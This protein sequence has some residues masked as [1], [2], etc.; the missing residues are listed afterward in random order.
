MTGPLFKWFGSKW[1]SAKH[2]PKPIFDSIVEPFAGG[3]GYSL[4]HA[5][6]K[7]ILCEA[8][9][10]IALLW[11]WLIEEATSDLVLQ[12][13]IGTEIGVDIRTMGLSQGQ[14]L[15]LKSWQRTNNVGNCWT[16]SKWGNKPGQWTKNTRS[17][18]AAEIHEIKHWK[19]INMDAFSIM[20]AS[21]TEATWFIDPPYQYNYS[22]R[23]PPIDYE[24]LG[25]LVLNLKGQIIACEAAC[26]KTG[27]EPT[28]LPFCYFGDRVTSR[29]SILNNHH[30]KELIW[31]SRSHLSN[32]EFM[33]K[34]FR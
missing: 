31:E 33:G 27:Q 16:I 15:L 17:R 23:Q 14:A 9:Q 21:D 7:V 20:R 26:Q 10:H 18:V 4:R 19:I 30:S 8:D 34:V 11:K 12:I 22:Y 6:K 13:P 5:T 25:K 3:A 32:N 28:W 24:L 2:L 1:L 29:R